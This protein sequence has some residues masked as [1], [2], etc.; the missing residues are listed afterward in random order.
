MSFSPD[1]KQLATAGDDGTARVWNLT[2]EQVAE[3]KG[4][5]GIVY[6]V[7]FSPDGKQL[8]TAGD[9]G[10]ARVWN[11]T[12][13]QVAELKGHQGIVYSVSFS[14]DG[15]QLATAGDY[16]IV[17]LPP[18]KNL[19]QLLARGCNWLPDYLQNPTVELSKSDRTLCDG[20]PTQN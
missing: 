6:S 13:E 9:D 3:L 20:I 12:G 17:R 5:Q 4:H 18:V 7:S 8:A 1:G 16:G 14:P 15:K 11:L 10:T 2:G 19:D